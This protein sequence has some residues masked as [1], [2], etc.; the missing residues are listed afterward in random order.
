MGVLPLQFLRGETP[1]S[2][3]LTGRERFTIRGVADITPRQQVQVEATADDGTTITFAALARIDA[4]AEVDYLRHGGILPMVLR[5]M[6]AA[7][8]PA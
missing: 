4:P 6:I 1:A 5:R 7:A 8:P 3:G 2:L